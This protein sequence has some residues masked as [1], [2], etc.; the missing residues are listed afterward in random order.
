MREEKDPSTGMPVTLFTLQSIY[1]Q[2]AD[3]ELL[4]QLNSGRMDM[5][6]ILPFSFALPI[7][8]STIQLPHWM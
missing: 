6:V 8:L 2:N 3:E 1:A 7:D 4:F 5:V